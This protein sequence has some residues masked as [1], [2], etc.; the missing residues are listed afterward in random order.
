MMQQPFWKYLTDDGDEHER[1]QDV[2]LYPADAGLRRGRFF[3]GKG[4]DEA[5]I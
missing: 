1:I 2:P 4:G 5:D 3:G